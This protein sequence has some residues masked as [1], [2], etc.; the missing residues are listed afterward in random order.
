[1]PMDNDKVETPQTYAEVAD[2]HC[3]AIIDQ[4]QPGQMQLMDQQWFDKISA[5]LTDMIMAMIESNTELSVFDDT[6]LHEVAMRVRC[7]NAN[8]R[9]WLETYVSKLDK[10]K[11][12][13][14]AKLVLIDFKDLSKPHKFNVFYR[15]IMKSSQHISR[16]LETQN[17]GI[18]TKSWSVLH[19]SQRDNDLHMTIGVGQESFDTLR[20]R[21][22]SLYCGMGKAVFTLVKNCKQNKFIT[23]TASVVK[24]IDANND[25]SQIKCS[26]MLAIRPVVMQI[27]GTALTWPQI[28]SPLTP[29]WG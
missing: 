20:E 22:N 21:S 15:G 24:S 23:Q 3:M 8:T 17:K 5:L 4:R 12:R 6:R 9:K 28:G 10:K 11:L 1:M 2:N 18:T 29:N 14:G 27:K 26:K 7:A 25:T 13:K 16:L 19:F